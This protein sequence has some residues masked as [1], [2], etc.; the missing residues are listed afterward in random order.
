M[1]AIIVW[2]EI[3]IKGINREGKKKNNIL[4]IDNI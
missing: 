1:L 4:V 2:R 3:E